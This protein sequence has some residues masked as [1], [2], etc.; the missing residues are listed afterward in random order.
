MLA[1]RPSLESLALMRLV[2]FTGRMVADRQTVVN[3]F[4]CKEKDEVR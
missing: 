4:S 2:L 3:E 1:A